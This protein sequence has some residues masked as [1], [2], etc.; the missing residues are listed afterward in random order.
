MNAVCSRIE[1]ASGPEGVY[2]L[3]RILVGELQKVC[4]GVTRRTRVERHRRF[5]E[6]W[7]SFRDEGRLPLLE[8]AVA[9]G[10][11]VAAEAGDLWRKSFLLSL[12]SGRVPAAGALRLVAPVE[13]PAAAPAQAVTEPPA[14]LGGRLL[15]VGRRGAAALDFSPG[16]AGPGSRQTDLFGL[17]HGSPSILGGSPCNV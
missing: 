1:A 3:R 16:L 11:A 4:R 5:A 7:R 12:A 6:E 14:T 17:D 2:A 15:E 10:P 13:E 9:L 8:R